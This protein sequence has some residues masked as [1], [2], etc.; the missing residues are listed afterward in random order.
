M[1]TDSAIALKE[2][3]AL[4][5]LVA[6]TA[7]AALALTYLIAVRT[8]LG[9]ALDT[10]IM[11]AVSARLDGQA[12][13]SEVLALVSPR[14]VVVASAVLTAITAVWRGGTTALKVL[15]TVVGTILA[16]ALLKAVL[17]RPEF[18][19][20]AT[21]SL[22]SGHVAA[23]AGVAAAATI[24]APAIHRGWTALIGATATTITGIATLA[25]QWHRPSDVAAAVLLA[26][27]V[28]A[29]VNTLPRRT[30]RSM[31]RGPQRN[32]GYGHPVTINAHQ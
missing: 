12:W 32:C 10:R 6:I 16:A 7:S 25:L 11:L 24:A 9:Q 18:L 20:Q 3:Q 23:V 30:T 21:N 8:P 13:P 17:V 19:D 27:F 26:V 4:S 31:S 5:L 22:P 29:L 15:A 1:R 2:Q 14:S 28:W